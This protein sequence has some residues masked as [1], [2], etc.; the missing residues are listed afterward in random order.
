ML[1][2]QYSLSASGAGCVS[3]NLTEGRF[4]WSEGRVAPDGPIASATRPRPGSGC[5]LAAA[6]CSALGPRTGVLIEG[7]H[8]MRVGDSI[9]IDHNRALILSHA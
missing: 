4:D 9:V 8:D 5:S 1:A 2:S 7:N 6:C 3:S